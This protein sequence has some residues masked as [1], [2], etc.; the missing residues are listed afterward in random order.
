MA[1]KRLFR[2][3]FHSQGK[4]YQIFARRVVQGSLHGFVEVSGLEFGEASSVVIDP[5]EDRLKAEFEGVETTYIPMHA[6]IRIDEVEKRGPAK[7]LNLEIP[8]SNVIPYP[9]M[10]IGN[11]KKD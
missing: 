11:P 10:P 5:S 7:I 9:F 8:D 6:V 2:I 3:Q 4:V 1:K